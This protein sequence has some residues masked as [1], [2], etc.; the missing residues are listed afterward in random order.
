MPTSRTLATSFTSYV[1]LITGIVS[2][3]EL[4]TDP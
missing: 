2:L 3:S 4:I 1:T